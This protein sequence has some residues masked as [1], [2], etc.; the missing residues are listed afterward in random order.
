MGNIWKDKR[1]C[2]GFL[3]MYRMLEM[4]SEGDMSRFARMKN[5][6]EIIKSLG[7]HYGPYFAPEFVVH[8]RRYGDP[9]RNAESARRPFPSGRTFNGYLYDREQMMD[10]SRAEQEP[11][12][13]VIDLCS[14]HDE[15]DDTASIGL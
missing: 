4:T 2:R 3:E 10:M 8:C 5:C 14:E 6:M 15:E 7:K 12:N 11:Q 1:K 13:F 9:F